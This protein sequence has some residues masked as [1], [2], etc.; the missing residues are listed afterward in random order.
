M[1]GNIKF[2]AKIEYL[3]NILR[4]VRSCARDEGFSKGRIS[5]IEL[6]LE[7]ALANICHHAYTTDSCGDM[8]IQCRTDDN[9]RLII[10]IIDTGKPFNMLSV[11]E[12]D[13]T[14][15]ISKRDLGGLGVLLIRRM[16]DD[17]HYCRRD[18]KNVLTFVLTD[19]GMLTIAPS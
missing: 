10:E 5:N 7:E 16:V 4:F 18:N 1:I 8:E 13:L 19:P 14:G 12:P 2:P 6:A 15:D 3:E 11:S 17:I 9:K